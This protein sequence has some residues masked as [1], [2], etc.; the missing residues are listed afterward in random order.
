MSQRA[1]TIV[2]LPMAFEVVKSMQ[3]DNLDWG[4]DYRPFAR[5]ALAEIIED[6][7][8][9]ALLVEVGRFPDRGGSNFQRCE[10]RRTPRRL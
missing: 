9:A 3:V 1:A 6:Q 4:E 8:A 5:Q 10:P 7:M 2:S